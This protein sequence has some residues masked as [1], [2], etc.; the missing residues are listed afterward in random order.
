MTSLLPILQDILPMIMPA[1][2]QVTRSNE[3]DAG[4]GQT[5]GMVRKGAI[6][7]KSKKICASGRSLLTLSKCCELSFRAIIAIQLRAEVAS[8]VFFR[9][10]PVI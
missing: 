1:S 7:D 10:S 3:L 6:I 5:E 2:V 9:K 4:T 8:V